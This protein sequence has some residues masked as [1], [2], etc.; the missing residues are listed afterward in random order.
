[1]GYRWAKELGGGWGSDGTRRW[2][3]EVG[4]VG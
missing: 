1:M 2:D 3:K 4:G